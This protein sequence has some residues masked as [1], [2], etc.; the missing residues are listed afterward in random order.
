[1]CQAESKPQDI[2][3]QP[4]PIYDYQGSEPSPEGTGK[5]TVT[6]AEKVLC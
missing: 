4:K 6:D 3:N 5:H 1:M 2:S